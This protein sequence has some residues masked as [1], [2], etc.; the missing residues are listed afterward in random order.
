MM[1]AAPQPAVAGGFRLVHAGSPREL[2]RA[3]AFRRRVFLERRG[4]CFDE[5]LEAARDRVGLVFLLLE[6]GAL[7]A[8]GRALPLPSALSPLSALQPGIDVPG[9]DSELGRIATLGSPAGLTRSLTLLSL[10]ARFLLEHTRYRRYV[11]YCHPKLVPLYRA[12]GAEETG[13]SVVVP[14]RPEPHRVIAGSYT[15]AAAWSEKLACPLVA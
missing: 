5:A 15:D 8:S 11:A 4:V 1:H 13:D 10:G 7:V 14:G 2:E 3:A 12:V 6:D 9:A